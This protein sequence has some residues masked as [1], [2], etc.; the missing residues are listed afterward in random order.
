[1]WNLGD[2]FDAVAEV[3]PPE[4]QAIVQGDTVVAWG[5]LDRRT[6]RLARGLLALA[7][8]PHDCIAI[9]ARN[10]PAYIEGFVACLKARL[11]PVN[12]NYRYTADEIAYVLADC[13]AQGLIYQAEF[14]PQ[15]A[16]LRARFPHLRLI[17][18]DGA[19][20]D[21]LAFEALAGVGDGS[22]LAITRSPEDPFLLYTGGTTGKPKGVVWPGNA[23]RQVQMEAPV[24]KHRPTTLAEHAANVKA[25]AAPG[26][27]LP[28]CPLMHG[29]GINATLSELI[30]GGTGIVL[31]GRGFDAGELWATVARH[32]VSRVLM[33]G[34]VFARPLLQWLDANPDQHDLSS[35]KLMSSAGLMWS[36]E[37]KQGLI[38]HMPWISLLDV[39]GASEAAGLGYSLMTKD[40]DVPTGRFDPAPVTVLISEDGKVMPKGVPGDGLVARP[41]PLPTGYLGDPKKTAEVFRVIDGVRYAIPG[42]WARIH[43]D[44]TME[45]I[46]RGSL[47]INTGGEKVF[48]EEVEEALKLADGVDDAIVVGLPDPTWGSIAV[49]LVTWRGAAAFDEDRIKSDV[50]IQLAPYKV[51]KSVF[52]VDALPRA[53]SGKGD[54]ARARAIANGLQS[55]R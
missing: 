41:Y 1:M 25:N 9:L 37:V 28:A 52:V 42:D 24:V 36:R 14:A 22:R 27:V 48:V 54:Y 16:S 8:A 4:R 18:I 47:V 29:A 21:A 50:R 12:V 32:R 44:G 31:A 33:V 19:E 51:P 5:E 38:R 13:T 6:N 20:G 15:V 11:C 49:A 17:C 55:Q 2:M 40:R 45:L 53:E 23:V 10:H 39:L 3:V 30:S 46:G 7:L 26:R 43:A 35:L 34:D